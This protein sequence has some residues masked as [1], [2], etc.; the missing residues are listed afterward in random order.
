MQMHGQL[1]VRRRNRTSTIYAR[2]DD[3]VLQDAQAETAAVT[4]R[5]T[6]YW[7]GSPAAA[8]TMDE[9]QNDDSV[10]SIT[11][12]GMPQLECSRWEPDSTEHRR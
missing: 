4:A 3:T 9:V 6:G 7:H 12:T 5:A 1:P 10:G 11:M 2:L 8:E